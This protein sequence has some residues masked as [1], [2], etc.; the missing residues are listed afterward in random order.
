MFLNET[1]SQIL[2]Y[3]DTDVLLILLFYYKDLCSSCI[4]KTRNNEF[5]FQIIHENLGRQACKALLGFDSFSGWDQ[6]Q[7]SLM[8]IRSFHA[9]IYFDHPMSLS[10]KHFKHLEKISPHL[11]MMDLINFVMDLYCLKRPLTISNIGELRW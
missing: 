9:G 1:H 10:W 4:F 11:L 2:S 3:S 8:V 7:A 6:K 5:K